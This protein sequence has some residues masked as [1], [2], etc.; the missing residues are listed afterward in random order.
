MRAGGFDPTTIKYKKLSF[1]ER[2]L[3]AQLEII[4]VLIVFVLDQT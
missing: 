4:I 1:F 2:V 3:Y